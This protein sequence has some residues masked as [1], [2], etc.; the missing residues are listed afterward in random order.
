[1]TR[2]YVVSGS[3]SGI[4]AATAHHLRRLGHRVIGID[5]RDADIVADLSTDDGRSEAVDQV[6]SQTDVVHGLVPC[7]GI[8]G[9]T[10][11]DP[12]LVVSVNFF[13]A[14][15]LLRG[16]RD[17][18][19]AARGAGVVMLSSNSVS[20]QPGWNLGVAEE[21]LREDEDAARK[22]A[23]DLDAVH[24]Y[25]ATKAALAWWTRQAAVAPEWVDAGIRINA[26]AP[27][28]VTTPMTDGLREDPV[29]GVFADSYPSAL[30]RPGRADEVAGT[31]G[32]LLS[33]AASLIVGSV[34]F[35]DGGTDAMMHP[36]RPAAM[37]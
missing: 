4:G 14:L 1:M 34:I 13:G 23:V 27:G 8:A 10:G 17:E 2:T 19:A 32:F 29:L 25:P 36:M 5:R 15:A 21:C 9:L 37:S 28:L 26:L 7:A 11:T 18:L 3:A 22:A 16:L 33:E 12:E 24:V 31:I 35:I 30:G 6:R 20:C